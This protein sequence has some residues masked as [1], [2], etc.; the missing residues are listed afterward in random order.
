MDQSPARETGR[1]RRSTGTKRLLM[2]T[3]VALAVLV[4]P[5]LFWFG[6]YRWWDDPPGEAWVALVVTAIVG[7]SL[8]LATVVAVA[9]TMSWQE[10]P[11]LGR[12]LRSVA[13]FALGLPLAVVAGVFA[14][15]TGFSCSGGVIGEG[16]SGGSPLFGIIFGGL[17][18][19]C[20]VGVAWHID[21][22]RS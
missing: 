7:P 9:S 13:V 6:S 17:V 20:T 22:P 18:L 12:L 21:R 8:A 15:L 4:Y 11:S 2:L 14:G 1:R 19:G 10:V 5:I 16:C 3:A